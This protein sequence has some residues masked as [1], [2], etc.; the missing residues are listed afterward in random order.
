VVVIGAAYAVIQF[1]ADS[2]EDLIANS[3]EGTIEIGQVVLANGPFDMRLVDGGFVQTDAST[4]QIDITVRNPGKESALL[5]Q[6]RITVEDS[7]RLAICEYSSGDIVPS[8][9]DYAL[10]L[11]VLP[12]PKERVVVR[13]LH[14]EVQPGGVDRFRLLFKVEDPGF[15]N[16]L[17]AV[18][19]EL[20]TDRTHE[21]VEVG[22]FVLG[23]PAPSRGESPIL[24]AGSALFQPGV[25]E[26]ERLASTWCMRRNLAA[27]QRIMS[28]P[29]KRS[30]AMS[31][32]LP[33]QAADWWKA[34]ADPRSP[35]A[36]V[37]PLLRSPVGEGPVLAVFAA[38]ETGDKQLVE[39]IRTE[40]ARLML[41]LAK[42]KLASPYNQMAGSATI[43]ARQSFSLSPSQ[44]ALRALREA[45]ARQ[46]AADAEAEEAL[47]AAAD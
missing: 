11:P 37:E 43:P 15:D 3:G 8:S 27:V 20:V 21:R 31:E 29:G 22:R 16:Y 10:A 35:R 6:A 30:P 2:T 45:E 46:A 41:Q 1:L 33:F 32:L 34:F 36:A 17:F 26:S 47:S 5:T 18:R 42:E 24:P 25:R 39:E 7:D 19:V 14:Q 38:E 12:M 44:E 40:A 13:P 4:P 9:K 23:L 28:E